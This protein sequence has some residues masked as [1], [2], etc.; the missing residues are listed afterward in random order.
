MREQDRI[1]IE[2]H[3]KDHVY[4][5]HDYPFPSNYAIN[6]D[7]VVNFFLSWQDDNNEVMPIGT[8]G[9]VY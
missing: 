6:Q 1:T 3:K 8:V 2:T 4:E 5:V 9:L 7:M